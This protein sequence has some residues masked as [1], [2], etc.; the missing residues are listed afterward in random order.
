MS[1]FQIIPAIDLKDHQVVRLEKGL[2]ASAK[3][4]HQ[5]PLIMA[6]Q[7]IDQGTKRLHL[8][9]LNGAFL[10][11]PVHFDIVR[12]IK[13]QNP[14]VI[15]Q[16][17]GGIR[18]LETIQAYLD[19]GVDYLILGT[20]AIKKPNL[21]RQWASQFPNTLILGLDAK[22]GYVATEGW[23]EKSESKATEVLQKF[24]DLQL[25]GVIY[26]DIAKD[27]MLSGP[28]FK[29]TQELAASTHLPVIASGGLSC[30]EDIDHLIEL[31]NIAGV[32]AGKA[33]YEER[34][35]LKE[36]LLRAAS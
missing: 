29:K 36:A 1:G 28:N 5:D 27:G 2:M 31:K 24:D 34:F 21:F 9:D 6:Q 7:W 18:T 25:A 10:G 22:D 11:K 17:G 30:L 26:T 12:K 14:Q 23:D 20:I 19:S 8:V 13:K 33:L 35:D 16:V 4:Y 32:I 15:V 3:V